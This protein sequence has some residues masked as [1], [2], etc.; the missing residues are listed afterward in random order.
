V[1]Q[2][3][4]PP[5]VRRLHLLRHAKSSWADTRLED[6]ERP[7]APRGEQALTLLARHIGRAGVAPGLVLCSP[8]RRTR[9]TLAGI[10]AALP[11]DVRTVVEDELYG[12]SERVLFA[13]LRQ[14][15]DAVSEVMVIGHN[16]GLEELAVSLA[17]SG[18]GS[19]RARLMTKFPTGA[20]ATFSFSARWAE[21]APGAAQLEG[22]VVPRDL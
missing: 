21:L 15:P 17:G 3:G 1:T 2:E 8:A 14:V 18:D 9:M 13:R 22:F 16:P 11:R 7:L 20:L 5:V 12:A 6:R 4:E 10:A 19:L